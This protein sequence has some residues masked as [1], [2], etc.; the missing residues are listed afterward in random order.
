[1]Q[2][3]ERELLDSEET[4]LT[5]QQIP[6]IQSTASVAKVVSQFRVDRLQYLNTLYLQSMGAIMRAFL[7][8]STLLPADVVAFS[9]ISHPA[10]PKCTPGSP[11]VAV[12]P[13]TPSSSP[14]V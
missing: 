9:T 4:F 6:E 7:S 11:D 10:P 5:Q 12:C 1:M 13:G 8:Y 2:K 14:Y 3:Q